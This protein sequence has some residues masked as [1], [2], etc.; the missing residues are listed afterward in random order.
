MVT[1]WGILGSVLDCRLLG[2]QA[3]APTAYI[4]A[5][6]SGAKTTPGKVMGAVMNHFPLVKASCEVSVPIREF[7]GAGEKIP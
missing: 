1:L 6:V 3:P 2:V 5:L 7:E 4:P